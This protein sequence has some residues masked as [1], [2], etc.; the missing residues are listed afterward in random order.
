ML[1]EIIGYNNIYIGNIGGGVTLLNSR[2]DV[3]GRIEFHRNCAVFGGG[4]ALSGRCLVSNKSFCCLL[5]QLLPV[6]F[7][8]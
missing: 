1:V 7:A 5:F 6:D 4:L 2:L 8:P 3:K